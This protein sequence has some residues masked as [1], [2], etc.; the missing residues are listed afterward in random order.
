MARDFP[1]SW[2]L[3]SFFAV[4][5]AQ[6]PMLVGISLPAYTAHFVAAPLAWPDALA[7]CGCVAG[8]ACGFVADNEL[9]RYM[10]ASPRPSPVL[11]SG[12]WRYSRHPNY[13]GEQL[14]WWSFAGFAILS[15]SGG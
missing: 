13:F 8:L 3:L 10:L 6:R 15:A 9:R 14:W 2:W 12:I 5:L 11:D 4:G 1:R 7:A